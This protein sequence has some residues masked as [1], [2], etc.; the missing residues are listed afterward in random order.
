MPTRTEKQKRFVAQGDGVPVSFDRAAGQQIFEA[1]KASILCMEFEP[2]VL[3][4]ETDIARR[5]SASRTPVREAFMRLR[6]VGLVDTWP[7]R[8]NFVTKLSARRIRE[9]RYIR[10]A[11]ELANIE[12]LTTNGVDDTFAKLLT[13]N[14]EQQQNVLQ[15]GRNEAFQKLDDEF[16]LLLANATGHERVATL[17]EREKMVLD[18]LRVLKLADAEHRKRLFEEHK[19][20]LDA[21]MCADGTKAKTKMKL[22]L[23]SI[24]SMLSV[25]TREH[26]SYFQ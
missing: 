19:S 22:H 6:E 5:F 1:V 26:E 7:S 2:G 10:E 25:L 20:I 8:G 9:A 4:S 21:V 23:A 14:L 12:H 13:T 18:R 16:H 17:L 24:L 11:L 3:I 15:S